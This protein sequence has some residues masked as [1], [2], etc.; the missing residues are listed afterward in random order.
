M[1]RAD[2]LT[3]FGATG[4]LAFKQIFPSL[5]KMVQADQLDIPVV[6]VA[7]PDWDD[8]QLHERI[9]ES[10]LASQEGLDEEAFARLRQL[11][12]YVG[13]DYLSEETFDKLKLSL[14]PATNPVHYLAIPPNIFAAVAANLSR[15]DLASRIVV[16]KPFGRNLQ[17]AQELNKILHQYFDEDQ[18]FRID[19]FL[20]K[21]A[22]ENILFFRFANE[23]LEPLFNRDHVKQIQITMAEE[24]DVSTR[25]SFYDEVGAIRDVIENHLFQVL[26]L[27]TMDPFDNNIHG[28]MRQEKARLLRSVRALSPEDLIRGQYQGYRQTEGVNPHSNTET[29]AAMKL[30]IDSWRWSGVPVY[31]RAG[32][33]M[34][35]T[36]T[37]VIIEL[38]RPSEKVVL[39]SGLDRNRLR[40]QINPEMIIALEV[41]ALRGDQG[42]MTELKAVNQAASVA[43]PYQRLLNAAIEGDDGFFASQETIE[44]A[45]RIVDPVLDL[46]EEP[47]I[48]QPGSWGP[49]DDLTDWISPL[50]N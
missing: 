39:G 2:A 38:K 14:S 10:L 31:I 35:R 25:G 17:S 28:Q 29:Y 13:G 26:T 50:S 46:A 11:V 23:F 37:E 5:Q 30:L 34:P 12:S 40:F 4:D 16:E 43:S 3:I 41:Q 1:K 33:A 22:V 9:R 49:E 42:Q 8:A 48:Y 6:A 24:F 18:I 44:E 20:G 7:R 47:V 15:A 21:N 32:K 45:W 19:H 27:L 36:A